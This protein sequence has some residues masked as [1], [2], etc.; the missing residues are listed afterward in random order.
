[1]GHRQACVFSPIYRA[2]A[3]VMTAR[4][5]TNLF[6]CSSHDLKSVARYKFLIMVS[7]H[8]GC[9]GFSYHYCFN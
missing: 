1:M 4:A 3:P 9:D 7:K 6:M 8:K 5:L 2:M